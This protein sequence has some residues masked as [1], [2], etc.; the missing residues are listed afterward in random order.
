MSLDQSRDKVLATKGPLRRSAK[1]NGESN[2]AR[3]TTSGKGSNGK[4]ATRT[5]PEATQG[6]PQGDTADPD[7]KPETEQG[8]VNTDTAGGI[9]AQPD[10]PLDESLSEKV[11]KPVV[12][13]D[14]TG[15]PELDQQGDW[16]IPADDADTTK[17]SVQ[18]DAVS[19][20]TPPEEQADPVGMDITE[21][22]TEQEQATVSQ[23]DDASANTET[24]TEAQA[25]QTDALKDI[26]SSDRP[27]P[28]AEGPATPEPSD[29]DASSRGA[30][31]P[32][33][34]ASSPPPERRGGFFPL[35]L[36][37]LVAGAIGY[38]AHYLTQETGSDEISALRSELAQM[39]ADLG[40]S[41]AAPDLSPIEAELDDLRSQLSELATAQGQLGESDL[42][43]LL[44]QLRAEIAPLETSD[45]APLQERI[46]TVEQA[47]ESQQATA[48]EGQTR[49]SAL[50]ADLADL[51]DLSERRVAEAEAAIDSALARSGLESMRAALQTGAPYGDA[52]TR[53]SDAGVEVP[54]AL[55]TPASGGVATVESL[56]ERFPEA[57]RSALR[58][59][60][61]DAPA[62]STVDR[63]QNFLRAQIGARSTVPRDG[64]DPDAV[65]SRAAAQV[66][67]G[68]IETALTELDSLPTSAQQAMRP[69]LDQA[70]ARV[71]AEAALPDLTNAIT[72]E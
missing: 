34:I 18:P 29:R 38:G 63:L 46:E 26:E 66:E 56:Q 22:A 55:A 58:V 72:T 40:A 15:S 52:V 30:P 12:P 37:G 48:S 24:G 3:K 71:A 13:D 16:K 42:E 21:P 2:L 5:E 47:I 51:R 44:D 14:T 35:I 45:L 49:L 7:R 25:Q 32:P 1:G 53:L 4:S 11:A 54:D 41:P 6:L 17:D 64:D 50:E 36:G 27:A 62:E 61:Q 69:W 9:A 65:L 33:P 59:A 10:A 67:A 31:P 57:A 20:P 8:S 60:L 43:A 19:G 23:T 28:A 39:R 68:D 70:Q